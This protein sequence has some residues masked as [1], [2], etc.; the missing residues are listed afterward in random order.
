M[1]PEF[2]QFCLILALCLAV[3]Q[4]AFPLCG[5]YCRQAAW[6]NMA[7][8]LAK[9]Q[10][11]LVTSSFLILVF[12]FIHNDFSVLYVAENSNT[13]LPFFYRLTAIWGAHEGSMLL[14]VEILACWT[15][16]VSFAKKNITREMHGLVI[17][18]LGI[19][20]V[21]FLL[22]ILST[23]DPFQRILPNI[24]LNGED[25][26]PL[27]QDPGFVSHPPMLYTGYVGFAVP[28]AFALAGLISGKLDQAWVKWMRPWTLIAWSFLT[29]GIILGSWWAY[30]ELG[31]GGWWF[32]D[33][34][35]NASFMPW[36]VGAALVH[37][38]VVSDKRGVFKSWTLLLA[39]AAFALSLIGT[40][41]V[42]SGI[43]ISVH[44]FAIDP[45]RGD[46][47][48]KFLAFIIGGSLLIYALRAH[49]VTSGKVFKLISRETFLLLNNVILAAIAGTVLIGTLYPLILQALNWGKISVGA[50]YFNTVFVPFMI[51]LLLLMGIGPHSQWQQTSLRLLWQRLR[52]TFLLSA[53]LGFLLPVV[54]VG[55]FYFMVGLGLS[56]ALWIIISVLQNTLQRAKLHGGYFRGLSQ[57]SFSHFG[58]VLGHIGLGV[59]VIG[60]IMVSNFSLAKTVRMQV[61]DSVAIGHYQIQFTSL[62]PFAGAN[63]QANKARIKISH[64]GQSQFVDAEQRIYPIREMAIAKVAIADNIWRD[65]Y[66]ALG[67]PVPH[68]QSWTFRLYVKPFV[69]WIWFGGIFILI[70]GLLAAIGNKKKLKISSK[71]NTELGEVVYEKS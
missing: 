36:L 10:F 8:P 12:C 18:F 23:S 26:N 31:W 43:L 11:I 19:V 53:L 48:L 2:G 55:K 41:L 68:S 60:V 44:A 61:G 14:W 21:G 20:S 4:V 22:F 13:K 28:F 63:F 62:T 16:A 38:L 64:L 27:L 33:P 5:Y 29:L 66:V 7:T 25:L 9:G 37:S 47:I 69:R 50:P 34:V 1:L 67:S 42:R 6:L 40:F 32:W 71:A 45:L 39:I 17:A 56:L 54:V 70:G 49:K 30:R 57:L 46:Y 58:M 59:S 24:P 65:V 3:A 52:I 51:L 35:E 15:L